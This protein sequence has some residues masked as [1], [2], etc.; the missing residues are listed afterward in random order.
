[1]QCCPRHCDWPHLIAL[2]SFHTLFCK[3]ECLLFPTSTHLQGP[4]PHIPPLCSRQGPQVTPFP[5]KAT[6][7]PSLL[8]ALQVTITHELLNF[9]A[10]EPEFFPLCPISTVPLISSMPVT[11]ITLNENGFNRMTIRNIHI[12]QLGLDPE[13]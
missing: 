2:T 10:V 1:M 9:L 7:L 4:L 5:L 3:P 8:K 11:W 13:M 12:K 6:G